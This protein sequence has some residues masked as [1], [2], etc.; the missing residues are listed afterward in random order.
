MPRVSLEYFDSGERRL[1]ADDG[2]TH[3]TGGGESM[4]RSLLI[5]TGR[6]E[7]GRE[8]TLSIE[9]S[10]T[11]RVARALNPYRRILLGDPLRVMVF[12]LLVG[13]VLAITSLYLKVGLFSVDL[14]ITPQRDQ[15]VRHVSLNL[16]Y[17]TQLNYGPWYLLGCPLVLYCLAMASHLTRATGPHNVRSQAALSTLAGHAAFQILGLSAF[18]ACS[19]TR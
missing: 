4:E 15:E 9:P 7:S 19:C 14:Q 18:C 16:G 17:L 10:R 11:L 5:H 6:S 1:R 13:V 8:M 2:E 12:A 3:G